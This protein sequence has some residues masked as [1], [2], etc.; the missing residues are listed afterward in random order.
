MV[1][2]YIALGV[3]GLLLFGRE[4]YIHYHP[5]WVEIITPHGD[6]I[7]V[8]SNC[9]EVWHPTYYSGYQLEFMPPSECPSCHREMRYFR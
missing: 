1:Y 8:C 9:G 6:K 7:Y 5:V 2:V 3:L 4:I